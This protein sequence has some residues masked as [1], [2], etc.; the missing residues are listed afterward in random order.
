MHIRSEA[1]L[2]VVQAE[3]TGSLGFYWEVI[4][5]AALVDTSGLFQGRTSHI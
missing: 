3:V 5:V 4:H 1:T 2:T